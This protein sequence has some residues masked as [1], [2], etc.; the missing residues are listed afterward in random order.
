MK[1]N[2]NTETEKY[3]FF[4]AIQK[5][6]KKKNPGN[7]HGPKKLLFGAI[8]SQKEKLLTQ[9]I[10][11]NLIKNNRKENNIFYSTT[12]IWLKS[13]FKVFLN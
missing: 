3:L 11:K 12:Q 9:N 13:V 8:F 5:K 2:T 1:N 6:K 7:F 10:F 4:F